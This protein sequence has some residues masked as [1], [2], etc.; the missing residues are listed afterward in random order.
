MKFT[1]TAIGAARMFIAYGND[2]TDESA[3]RLAKMMDEFGRAGYNQAL[4][5][6]KE[7][8]RAVHSGECRMFSKGEECQCVLCR[9]DKLRLS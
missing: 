4:D 7:A 6:A 9:L 3:Q 2:G 5:A 1:I 8:Y